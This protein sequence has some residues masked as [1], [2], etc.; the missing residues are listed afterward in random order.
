MQCG[1]LEN[2]QLGEKC[3]SK[4]RLTLL[5]HLLCALIIHVKNIKRRQNVRN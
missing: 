5:S 1:D 2:E 3:A 4:E